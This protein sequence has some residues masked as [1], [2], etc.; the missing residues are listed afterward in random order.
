MLIG[1]KK[2]K[3]EKEREKEKR[4][5]R[6]KEKEKRKRYS[7]SFSVVTPCSGSSPKSILKLLRSTE[8]AR[9]GSSLRSR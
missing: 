4:E 8:G 1:R 2:K 9:M 3:K 5:E 7:R 6:R